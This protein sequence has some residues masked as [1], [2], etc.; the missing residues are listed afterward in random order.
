MTARKRLLIA[1]AGWI[2]LGLA[3][4]AYKGPHARGSALFVVWSLYAVFAGV[5]VV[6]PLLKIVDA[7][8]RKEKARES[9]R[10]DQS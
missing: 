7:A 4:I 9:S 2:L 10:P 6:M 8:M 3:V 1:F 5:W